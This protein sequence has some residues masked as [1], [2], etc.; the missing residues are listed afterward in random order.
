MVMKAGF[1]ALCVLPL[2]AHAGVLTVSYKGTVHWADPGAPYSIGDTVSG[3]LLIDTLL[4]GP[5]LDLQD[6]NAGVYGSDPAHLP[7][8]NFVT[9]FAN[10]LP[11]ND[12]IY[13]RNDLLQ[14]NGLTDTYQISDNGA[15]GTPSFEQVNLYAVLPAGTFHD[16][17]GDQ[18][19]E[20]V[21]RTLGDLVG[22]I[23]WGWEE[24]RRQVDFYMSSMS[25]KP[26]RCR[27]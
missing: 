17:R 27:A 22:T 11:A 9:G 21:S 13:V 5:D 12:S 10:S 3:T 25:V 18:T 6:P 24:T 26:G 2:S 4:M 15:F 14:L 23:A 19:F 20:A 1:V 16:D 8:T 7:T